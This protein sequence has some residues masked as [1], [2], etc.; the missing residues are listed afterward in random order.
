MKNSIPGNSRVHAKFLLKNYSFKSHS[1]KLFL[2]QILTRTPPSSRQDSQGA[3]YRRG[4]GPGGEQPEDPPSGSLV[5]GR[6]ASYSAKLSLGTLPLW[7]AGSRSV[8][9]PITATASTA[10]GCHWLLGSN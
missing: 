6:L 8:R 5:A 9:S 1:P 3:W 4:L 10:T 7:Q 2:L